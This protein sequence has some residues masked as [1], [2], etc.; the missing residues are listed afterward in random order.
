[1]LSLPRFLSGFSQ[2]N[3]DTLSVMG[4][5]LYYTNLTSP[6]CGWSLDNTRLEGEVEELKRF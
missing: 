1:M 2:G 4:Q 5:R 3:R 6:I